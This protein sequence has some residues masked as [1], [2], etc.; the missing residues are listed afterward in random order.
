M[1]LCLTVSKNCKEETDQHGNFTV[2]FEEEFGDFPLCFKTSLFFFLK[3]HSITLML[4]KNTPTSYKCQQTLPTSFFWRNSAPPLEVVMFS[5]SFYSSASF[6][7]QQNHRFA[8]ISVRTTGTN[9]PGGGE[10]SLSCFL[11]QQVAHN[12]SFSR[13]DEESSP[14]SELDSGELLAVILRLANTLSLLHF[15]FISF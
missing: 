5:T 8:L 2:G 3:P 4:R 15:F 1:S 6:P 7:Y 11:S 13:R 9:S 14:L 12:H 10:W